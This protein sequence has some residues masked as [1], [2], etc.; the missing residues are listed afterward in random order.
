MK[1]FR[2]LV[3]PIVWLTP[4]LVLA[5]SGPEL[6]YFES[7]FSQINELIRDIL[8][9]LVIGLAVLMFIW[10][11]IQYFILGAGDEEKRATGRWYILYAILGLVAIVSVWGIVDLVAEMLGVDIGAVAPGVGGLPDL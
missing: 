2:I 11:I 3:L 9:P 6:K 1:L 7:L 4:S 8:I 10:G 5:A